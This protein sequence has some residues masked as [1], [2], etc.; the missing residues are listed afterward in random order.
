MRRL[1]TCAQCLREVLWTLADA[2][3][4]LAVDPVPDPQGNTAVYRDG[5]GTYRSR[6]PSD[7]LPL[8][9]WERLHVPHV[10]TCPGRTRTPARTRP[11]GLPDGVSDLS[12][13]RRRARG[14][15]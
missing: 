10:A 13:Y 12:A 14:Q 1:S 6:R 5:A 2:G 11:E 15:S 4:R 7:E 3:K 9:A 8:M